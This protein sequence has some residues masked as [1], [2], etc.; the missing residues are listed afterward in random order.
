MLRRL[1]VLGL[2]VVPLAGCQ[3]KGPTPPATTEARGKIVLPGGQ[4][5]RS[6][7]VKLSPTT[8]DTVETFGDVGADGTFVL[9]PYK[10]GDGAVPGT[11]K[12]T[13]EPFQY[14]TA[15]GNPVRIKDAARIPP[16]YLEASSTDMRAV[17][18]SGPNTLDLRL[19]R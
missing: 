13:V 9:S 5:L 16:R 18:V 1:I 4:P 14:K 12:V 19:V 7:R 10:V 2:A 6:G 15:T 17:I 11:Y 3:S 8:P